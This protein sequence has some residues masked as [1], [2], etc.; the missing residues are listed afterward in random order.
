MEKAI[1]GMLC[2]KL[3]Q[4]LLQGYQAFTGVTALLGAEL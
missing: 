1:Q 3:I 2:K 4:M